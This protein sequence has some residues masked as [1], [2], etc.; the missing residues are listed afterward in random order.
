[1]SV[2]SHL[3]DAERRFVDYAADELRSEIALQLALAE[4]TLADPN[5]DTTALRNMGECIASR[6]RST[7][8]RTSTGADHDTSRSRRT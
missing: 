5:A 4:S 8:D 3:S 6:L 2:V 7:A 1:M